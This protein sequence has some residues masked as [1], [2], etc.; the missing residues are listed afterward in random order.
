VKI[1]KFEVS[2]SNPKLRLA[3][4]WAGYVAGY[5][6]LLFAFFYLTFPYDQLK[7]RIINAYATTQLGSPTPGHLE[8]EDLTWSF[9]FPGVV[10]SGIR[11]VTPPAATVNAGDEAAKPKVIALDE[12]SARIS[13][14][15]LLF[16]TQDIGFSADGMGGE[17]DGN[18]VIASSG[19]EY[20]IELNDIAPGEL[21]TIAETV[22]LPMTGTVNGKLNISLPEGKAALAQGD[23]KLT[24]DNLVIGDGKAK[25]RNTLAIPA[26]QVGTL[27]IEATI[28]SGQLKIEQLRA[29]G[30]DLELEVEGRARLHDRVQQSMVDL[31]VR[32]AFTDKY[33]GKSD[34]TKAIFGDP[35]SPAPGLFDLDP[36]MKRAKQSDGSYNF[37]VTGTFDRLRY[38]PTSQRIGSQKTARPTEKQEAK[39]AEPRKKAAKPAKVRS[40]APKDSGR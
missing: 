20:T 30:P 34:M 11:M 31:L 13:P 22:G 19:R 9:A 25:I 21:P 10:A 17:V 1:G 2:I 3:L 33:K 15:R 24:V 36:T 32:F 8:I 4:R 14:L 26:V 23:L 28:T 38:T 6:L 29:K 12:L 27:E 39:T 16:G 7:R 18:I 5:V 37:A 35:K 40:P